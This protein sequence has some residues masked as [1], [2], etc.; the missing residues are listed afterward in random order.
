MILEEQNWI[1]EKKC[2]PSNFYMQIKILS[3]FLKFFNDIIGK[4][5]KD[6]ILM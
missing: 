4:W 2:H 3:L 5:K 6:L 1:C